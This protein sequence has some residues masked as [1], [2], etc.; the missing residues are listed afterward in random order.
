MSQPSTPFNDTA[1][2]PFLPAFGQEEYTQSQLDD[3]FGSTPSDDPVFSSTNSDTLDSIDYTFASPFHTPFETPSHT[4]FDSPTPSTPAYSSYTL[5]RPTSSY[6]SPH[7]HPLSAPYY[8]PFQAHLHPSAYQRPTPL[9]AA[10]PDLNPYF[11]LPNAPPQNYSRRR[12]LSHNDADRPPNPTF[13]RLQAQRARCATSE[14]K[15]RAGPYG[16]HGRSVSQ[17]R[18]GR[19]GGAGLG[20]MDD[21]V[22]VRHMTDTT[23]LAHSRRIIE[24]GALGIRSKGDVLGTLLRDVG[25]CVEG[26]EE[27]LRGVRIV[28]E[29]VGKGLVVKVVEG[30]KKEEA[31]GVVDVP[32]RVMGGDDG[33][34]LFG[35]YLDENDLMALL[36]R[37]NE[38]VDA[39]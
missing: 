18:A 29:A 24:I 26:N 4:P 6:P 22:C 33:D 10:H 32:S 36:M 37:E 7:P 5:S 8:P 13:A 11:L 19:L 1:I 9:Y 30:E 25:R 15:R 39:A 23:Q 17:G 27:A 14:E 3:L 20:G 35:V 12:S 16:M 38:R 31:G 2:D 34:G 28:R 21:G